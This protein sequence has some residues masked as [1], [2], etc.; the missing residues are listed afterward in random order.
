MRGITLLALSVLGSAFSFP[1]PKTSKE[2]GEHSTLIQKKD[3]QNFTFAKLESNIT[4]RKYGS[5]DLFQF[6]GIT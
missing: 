4:T 3:I 6:E 2:V 5:G 1:F